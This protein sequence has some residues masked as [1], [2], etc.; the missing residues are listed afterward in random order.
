M[1]RQ[2]KLIKPYGGVLVDLLVYGKE[3]EQLKVASVKLDSITLSERALCDLEMLAIGA[4]SP[5]QGFMNEADYKSVLKDMRLANGTLF[6]MPIT[7]PV[8]TKYKLG[9]KVALRDSF[10]NLLA[11]MVID[12]CYEWSI[13]EYAKSILG[14]YDTAHPLLREMKQWGQY[15]I[16]GTLKVIRMPDHKD[17]GSLRMTPREVRQKLIEIG[18]EDIVAF[19]TRNPLHRAHEELTKRA[20]STINGTLL[21]HPAVG[22]TKPGDV[23]HITRVRCYRALLDNHYGEYRALLSLLPLAMRM[24]GPREA[25]WHAIVRRNYGANHFI[26]GRDHAGPGKNSQGLPF[27][28]PYAAQALARQYEEELGMHIM[29]FSE[30]L[31]LPQKDCYVE[32]HEVED[33]IKTASI[34]G[35]QVREDYLAK[36]ELLPEWF[37]RPEVAAVLASA[38]PPAI[39]QGFCLWFTGLSGA[40]K[41]TIAQAVEAAL[42]ERGRRTTM[43][44]GDIVR[45]NLSKGL[46]FSKEDRETNISRVGFVASEVVRH[47]GIAICALISPYRKARDN[48]RKLFPDGNFLEIFVAT[49]LEICEARDPK[50]HYIK[51]RRGKMKNLTGVDDTYEPPLNPEVILDTAVLSVEDSVDSILTE[52]KKRN[53]IEANE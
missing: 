6:P 35:T 24:A 26:V 38:Y 28:D 5:L 53:F 39:K 18:N 3:A 27:F 22:M 10:G 15:N 52:L 9:E 51:S 17:F 47:H 31:Y 25:L 46:G 32:A 16:S 48:V 41:S 4:F 33:G 12:D 44:D 8:Q 43:L 11:I 37:T 36:G 30:M 1:Q 34:S 19:Q 29:T 13:E 14:S 2:P 50:G 40:G 49:P 45:L 23:D 20:A 21:L 7:L 42:H